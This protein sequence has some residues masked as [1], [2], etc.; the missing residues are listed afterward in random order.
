[1]ATRKGEGNPYAKK[2]ILLDFPE[3]LGKGTSPL[4]A[5][6]TAVD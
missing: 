4:S 5:L 3:S 1:M 6:Q 2:K